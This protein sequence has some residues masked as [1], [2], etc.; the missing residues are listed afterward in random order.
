[1]LESK[2][3]IEMNRSQRI[4]EYIDLNNCVPSSY[5]EIARYY[6]PVA[7]NIQNIY[8][9]KTQAVDYEPHIESFPS[10]FFQWGDL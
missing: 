9:Q 8:L 5:R 3:I 7:I 10:C 4:L 1:M 6:Q 2:F